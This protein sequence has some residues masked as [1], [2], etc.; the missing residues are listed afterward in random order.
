MNCG[1]ILVVRCGNV[2]PFTKTP[3]QLCP[4]GSNFA[5]LATRWSC[6]LS[7]EMSYHLLN[8]DITIQMTLLGIVGWDVMIR[9]EMSY[10]L[11]STLHYYPPTNQF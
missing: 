8:T 10:H 7:W 4:F 5:L 11:L 1:E 3:L 2:L 9:W 6:Y